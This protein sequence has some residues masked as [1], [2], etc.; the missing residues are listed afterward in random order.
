M[1]VA[2]IDRLANGGQIV[3]P[4]TLYLFILMG[5]NSLA[6]YMPPRRVVGLRMTQKEDCVLVLI[7]C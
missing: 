5:D 2:D 6:T 7:K 4:A 1:Q 3:R